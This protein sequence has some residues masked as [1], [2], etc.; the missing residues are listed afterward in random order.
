MNCRDRAVEITR[1]AL[2]ECDTL[3]IGLVETRPMSEV[4]GDI[5]WQDSNAVVLP[6]LKVGSALHGVSHSRSARR[7]PRPHTS[8]PSLTR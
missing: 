5:E 1:K 3:T 4:C 8:S 2:F 7:I 6:A